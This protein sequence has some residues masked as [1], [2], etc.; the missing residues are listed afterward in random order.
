M[1][2][3]KITIQL[4]YNRNTLDYRASVAPNR[5]MNL[6]SFNYYNGNWHFYTDWCTLSHPTRVDVKGGFGDEFPM[7]YFTKL[8]QA[9]Y[10]ID[11]GV[12]DFPEVELSASAKKMLTREYLQKQ[13]GE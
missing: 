3:E 12:L 2:K 4:S 1:K 10:M 8:C 6:I 13:L 5:H 9:R 11:K 7:D